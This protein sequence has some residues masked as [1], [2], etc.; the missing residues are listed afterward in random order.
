MALGQKLDIESVIRLWN[1]GLLDKQIGA[2]L[3]CKAKSIS[4]Y[5]QKNGMS[6]N[7][8]IFKRDAEGVAK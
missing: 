7:F 8:G 1:K 6:S 2:I 5:R 4:N 3:G